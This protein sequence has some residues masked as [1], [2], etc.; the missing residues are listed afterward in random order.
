MKTD[1]GF[2]PTV[3]KEKPAYSDTFLWA[4]TGLQGLPEWTDRQV[5]R[6]ILFDYGL[7]TNDLNRHDLLETGGCYVAARCHSY[8]LCYEMIDW[9]A[10]AFPN[11]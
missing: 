6:K 9:K 8:N 5:N 7:E 4:T 10:L 2:K 11:P 3:S 1:K